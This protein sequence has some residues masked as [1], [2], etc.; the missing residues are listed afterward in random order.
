VR[1][2]ERR[3]EKIIVKGREGWSRMGREEPRTRTCNVPKV[4]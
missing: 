4:A 1:R 2:R 3:I